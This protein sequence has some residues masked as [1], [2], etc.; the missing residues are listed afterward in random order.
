MGRE[1]GCGSRVNECNYC[2]RVSD[3]AQDILRPYEELL[4]KGGHIYANTQ[5]LLH[6]RC[7]AP[8]LFAH[9]SVYL[10]CVS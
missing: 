2:R 6:D 1:P 7:V 3:S 8:Y 4:V 9:D 10:R 5:T